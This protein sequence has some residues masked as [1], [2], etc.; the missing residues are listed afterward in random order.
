MI[1]DMDDFVDDAIGAD[2]RGHFLSHYD[3][4]EVE[5]RESGLYIYRT[6]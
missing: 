3:G 2:G 1:K 6:N 5:D 4:N